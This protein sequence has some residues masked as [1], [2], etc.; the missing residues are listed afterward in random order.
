MM[1]MTFLAVEEHLEAL[2]LD[3]ILHPVGSDLAQHIPELV[4]HHR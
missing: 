4:I 1:M 2:L 3:N